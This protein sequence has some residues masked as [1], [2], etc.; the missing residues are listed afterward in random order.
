MCIGKISAP[1]SHTMKNILET[2]L[3]VKLQTNT[4]HAFC[5]TD[6][7]LSVPSVTRKRH[8]EKV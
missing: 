8:M 1:G 5:T 2:I 3:T 6:G 7:T 4:E